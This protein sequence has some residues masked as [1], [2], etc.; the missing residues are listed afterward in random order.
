MAAGTRA[1]TSARLTDQGHAD[2]GIV[3]P[4][5]ERGTPKGPGELP[6][7]LVV[8]AQRA[9]TLAVVSTVPER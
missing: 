4:R 8:G 9:F 6:E 3:A 5:A 7:A 1:Q 2:K